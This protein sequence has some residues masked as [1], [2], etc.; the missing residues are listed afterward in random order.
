MTT[1]VASS[2]GY[3]GFTNA[4]GRGS[5]ST[6]DYLRSK[7]VNVRLHQWQTGF[8]QVN[9]IDTIERL[10]DVFRDCRESGWGGSDEEAVQQEVVDEAEE[11]IQSLPSKYQ[12]PEIIPEPSGAIALEWT[13]GQ[14]RTI[15]LSVSGK[16]MIEYAGLSGRNNQ[17]FGKRVFTGEL[18][19]DI[20]RH[21][22]ALSGG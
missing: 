22:T 5:S 2:S 1:A 13:F 21:M 11:L 9:A 7:I 19:D 16:G 18:P 15:V 6:A 20:Y 10:K 4:S 3:L 14:F 17:F 8:A 12:A